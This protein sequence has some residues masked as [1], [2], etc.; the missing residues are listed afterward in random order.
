MKRLVSYHMILPIMI[1][2]AC[3][4]LVGNAVASSGNMFT[5]SD[6]GRTVTVNSGETFVIRLAENPTTGYSWNMTV[7]KGLEQLSDQYTPN[8]V[9]AM[10]VGS[11]GY[12]EW[13]IKASAPGTYTI[14]G[15]Y[16][17]PWEPMVGDEQKFTITVNVVSNTASTIISNTSPLGSKPVKELLDFKPRQLPIFM[18]I[19]DLFKRLPHFGLFDRL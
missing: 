10:V 4:L 12:H 8:E 16:K 7:G 14:S 18:K 3:V 17:R 11:G 2:L 13:A 5:E 6:N 1:L 19:S 15:V 9:P